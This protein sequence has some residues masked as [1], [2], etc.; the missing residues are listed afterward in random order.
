MPNPQ[1]LMQA[2]AALSFALLALTLLSTTLLAGG[3]RIW[4][5]RLHG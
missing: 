5:R 4:E 1:R 2:A 3:F